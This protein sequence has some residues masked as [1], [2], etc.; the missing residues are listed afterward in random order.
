VVPSPN[1]MNSVG[2]GVMFTFSGTK[3]FTT[4]MQGSSASDN[5]CP[6]QKQGALLSHEL[7]ENVNSSGAD[8]AK[9][10]NNKYQA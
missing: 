9:R 8:D 7:S 4:H 5:A 2:R 1:E 6:K 10:P 3:P